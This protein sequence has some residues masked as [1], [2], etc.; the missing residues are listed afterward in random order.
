MCITTE[1][2][3]FFFYCVYIWDKHWITTVFQIE[4]KQ[5]WSYYIGHY[6]N[7]VKDLVRQKRI[8]V[9]IYYLS[10]IELI[11]FTTDQINWESWLVYTLFSLMNV[12]NR[13]KKK[14]NRITKNLMENPTLYNIIV[15]DEEIV[16]N[17]NR[18]KTTQI[19][20]FLKILKNDS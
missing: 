15:T 18:K 13:I 3:I 1:Q 9:F 2:R 4:S 14:A 16:A 7:E 10:T 5:C 20:S 11:N 8:S 19:C 6:D 17:T 12:K